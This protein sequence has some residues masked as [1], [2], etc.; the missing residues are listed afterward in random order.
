V[1]A[2]VLANGATPRFEHVRTRVLPS[3]DAPPDMPVLTVDL[4]TYDGLIGT[5]VEKV[6]S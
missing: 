3:P 1:L 5:Q 4:A 6:A 2:E